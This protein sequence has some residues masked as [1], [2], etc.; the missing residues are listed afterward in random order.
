MQGTRSRPR[1][2]SEEGGALA[3]RRVTRFNGSARALLTVLLAG[4]ALLLQIP[5]TASAQTDPVGDA[6]QAVAAAAE[7]ADDA[8]EAYFA[9][10][11]RFE[12]LETGMNATEEQL[13]ELS[14]QAKRLRRNLRERAALAYLRAGN[15]G[16]EFGLGSEQ[17]ALESARR[18]TIL[19]GL[20]EGDNDVAAR[21]TDVTDSLKAKRSQL[22]ADR[23]AQAETLADLETE[24][25]ALDAKLAEAQA[26]RNEA[27]ARQQAEDAARA[28]AEAAAQAAA[29]AEAE[30]A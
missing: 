6:E 14:A 2:D 4:G 23:Q 27:V 26:I 18:K 10:L 19:D 15:N 3:R 16:V 9:Q 30:A 1:P 5:T 13:D 29:E 7:A 28:A 17:Q 21:L 20:N 22:E 8:A 12:L 11:N 24:Q 25:A